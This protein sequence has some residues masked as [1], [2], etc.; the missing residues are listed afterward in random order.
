[1]RHENSDP[2]LYAVAVAVVYLAVG[3]YLTVQGSTTGRTLL[4]LSPIGV[5]LGVWY[6]LKARSTTRREIES[7]HV[8]HEPDQWRSPRDRK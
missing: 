4:W 7:G 8:E 1:M 5:G 6:V 3:V 2:R